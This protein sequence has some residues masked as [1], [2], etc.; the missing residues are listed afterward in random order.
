MK[1]SKVSFYIFIFAIFLIFIK[2]ITQ[3][4]LNFFNKKGENE[5]IKLSILQNLKVKPECE[6]KLTLPEQFFGGEVISLSFNPECE[7]EIL[8]AVS[9]SFVNDKARRKFLKLADKNSKSEEIVTHDGVSHFNIHT[10]LV[11][12]KRNKKTQITITNLNT[13]HDV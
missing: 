1:L 5:M 8:E 7:E 6:F 13:K 12:I 9:F 2:I 4:Y 10:T 3:T 11:E